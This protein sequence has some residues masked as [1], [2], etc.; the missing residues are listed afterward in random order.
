MAA[1]VNIAELQ[2][3][4]VGL[5]LKRAREAGGKTLADISAATKIPE[6]LL[7]AIEQSE[8]SSLPSRIYAVGFS[9]SYA[10]LVGLDEA[11]VASDVRA[12][13]DGAA[14]RSEI[15]TTQ[16]FAPGDP[17]R[18]P[19]LRL[20]VAAGLG[21]VLVIVAGLVFWH[22]VYN[23][24]GSLPSI[25]PTDAPSASVGTPFA[26]P[27]IKP[28][29]AVPAPPATGAVALSALSAGIWVKVYEAS[30][31]ALFEKEMTLGETFTVPADAQ[32]PLIWTARPD[33]LAITVGGKPVAK[34]S[35][36]Q[37]TMKGVPFSA[38]ALLARPVPATTAVLPPATM[39]KATMASTLAQ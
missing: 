29:L 3:D 18:V 27:A 35:E 10:R 20:A 33:A 4:R 8:F 14:P 37:R 32:A 2:L 13:I 12:E 6:R 17:A 21:A 16:A 39:V 26:R 15:A 34:L 1:D 36:K 25:L 23:P 5:R 11:R 22:T 7:V 31:K 9:R 24:A 38:A 28:V 30:G 19:E